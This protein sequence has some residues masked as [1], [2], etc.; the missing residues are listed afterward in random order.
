MVTVTLRSGTTYVYLLDSFSL[1]IRQHEH[2]GRFYTL[3]WG[4]TQALPP[5]E[6][7]L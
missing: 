6:V 7:S 5:K 2:C 4:F 3:T 1:S